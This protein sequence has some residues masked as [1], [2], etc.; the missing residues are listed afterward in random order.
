MADVSFPAAP[1]APRWR[2]ARIN[3][4]LASGLTL[5]LFVTMHLIGHT[6]L[7]VSLDWAEPIQTALMKPWRTMPGTVLLVAALVYHAGHALLAVYR[8]RTLR[9]ARWEAW[10]LALGLAIPLFLMMHVIGTR[11]SEL[12]QGTTSFYATTLISLWISLPLVGIMQFVAVIVTWLHG[13]IGIHF[14]LRTRPGYARWQPALLVAALLLPSFA[15]AGYVSGGNQ[16]MRSAAQDPNFIPNAQAE[17]GQTR[18]TYDS[19]MALVRASYMLYAALLVL[20]FGARA[21]RGLVQR[22]RQPPRLTLATGRRLRVH[23]GASILETLRENGIAHAAICGGRA[24]CTTCRVLVTKGLDE[25]PPPDARE[26]RAL[27]RINATPGTR[28]ACQV[29]PTADMTVL[30]LL[31]P[32]ATARDG[33]MRGGLE[34]SERLITVLFVDLRGSTLLGERHLPYDVMFL[35]NR[36]FHEMTQ[37]L[38]ETR[39]HYSQFTGDGLMALYGLTGDPKQGARDAL[40]GADAMLKRLAHLNDTLA[41]ELRE[42]L[43]IGIGIHH[44]EAIVGAMGPPNSQIISAIGDTVNVCARLESLTKAH[45]VPLIVSEQTAQA[46]GLATTEMLHDAQLRG[47]RGNVRFYA[48]HDVPQLA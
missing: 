48:F 11:V 19:N 32:H 6:V 22:R 29:R 37:A 24:R 45:G 10:Q 26:T 42:P 17:A 36:F 35:L 13:C 27:A 44:A 4:N 40:R 34:G 28:L 9:M 46:A 5:M 18:A 8:R 33:S 31:A 3:W 12:T 23:P 47:R 39:G 25:V 41:R 30:P 38:V 14:W 7:L 20:P 1:P 2:S 15:I 21:V 16:V 43:R